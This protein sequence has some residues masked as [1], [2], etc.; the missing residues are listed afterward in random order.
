MRPRACPRAQ[1]AW[2]AHSQTLGRGRAH[3]CFA[4]R[5]LPARGVAQEGMFLS[6]THLFMDLVNIGQPL[7]LPYK[8]DQSGARSLGP[9]GQMITCRG[10]YLLAFS[11]RESKE[12]Y[13]EH[14]EL[15]EDVATLA[16]FWS[17]GF[18]LGKISEPP[19]G[20]EISGEEGQSHDVAQTVTLGRHLMVKGPNCSS[21][22]QA[23]VGV[24]RAR[25]GRVQAERSEG[26]WLSPPCGL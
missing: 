16:R 22:G 12:L 20:E 5:Q 17:C 1:R 18:P 8:G 10:V 21:Q 3:C 23:E 15:L 2:T 25:M 9:E 19:A 6:F 11:I 7:V 24:G 4:K 26:R 13:T 14:S